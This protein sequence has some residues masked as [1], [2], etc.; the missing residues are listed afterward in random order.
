[1]SIYLNIKV[2]N[3]PDSWNLLE[4]EEFKQSNKIIDYK[5]YLNELINA[6]YRA[7]ELGDLGY[8]PID[9]DQLSKDLK[10]NFIDMIGAFVTY[11]LTKPKTFLNGRNYGFNVAKILYTFKNQT[12]PPHIILSDT[13]KN[14]HRIYKSGRINGEDGMT[15]EQWKIFISEVYPK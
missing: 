13:V 11:E 14:P 8:M 12:F 10:Y 4:F 7:T 3:T 5:Q 6:G 2:G 15:K 1:M 9:P